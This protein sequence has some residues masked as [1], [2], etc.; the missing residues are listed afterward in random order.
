MSEK[1][2]DLEQQFMSC[3][4]VVDEIDMLYHY[5]GDDPKFTGLDAKAEDEMMN[6]LLGLKSLY[7]I[8]FETTF[9][10]FEDVC[11]EYHK[12]GKRIKELEALNKREPFDDERVDI[13]GQNGNDGLHY[14]EIEQD[15]LARDWDKQMDFD[16]VEHE[17][18]EREDKAKRREK[19]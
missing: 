17:K 5:F 7:E 11:R 6:L 16:F 15:A 3:W 9:K 19:K 18:Q 10:T 14:R 4:N 8:K 12:R 13:I 2:F 1:I